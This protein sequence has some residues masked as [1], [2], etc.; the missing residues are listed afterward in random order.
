VERQAGVVLAADQDARALFSG[1]QQMHNLPFPNDPT[2]V[3]IAAKRVGVHPVTIH[4]WIREGSLPA[5]RVGPTGWGKKRRVVV[6]MVQLMARCVEPVIS[7][8]ER[9]AKRAAEKTAY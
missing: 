9:A 8:P 2:P 6:S 1:N 4:R 7:T 3:V 5:W